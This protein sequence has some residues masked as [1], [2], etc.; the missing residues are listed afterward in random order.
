[1]LLTTYRTIQV[2][3]SDTLVVD[4]HDVSQMLRAVCMLPQAVELG[5]SPGTKAAT[6]E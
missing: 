6:N 5:S 3:G 4:V 1:M 2:W